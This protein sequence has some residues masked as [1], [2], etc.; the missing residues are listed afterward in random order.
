MIEGFEFAQWVK[1]SLNRRMMAKFVQAVGVLLVALAVCWLTWWAVYY[2]S[3]FALLTVE[4]SA[5]VLQLVT[6]V[7]FVLLFVIY[8]FANREVVERQEF[9]SPAKVRAAKA[10]AI[11]TDSPLQALTG[12]KSLAT[13][14][15]AI[16]AVATVGPGMLA[17]SWGLLKQAGAARSG[18]PDLVG[19]MLAT[20]AHAGTRVP[21]EEL[22]RL[23]PSDR[24]ETTFRAVR[25]F[26]GVIVRTSDPMG[27]ALS[28]RL[29]SE[30]LKTAPPEV[31]RPQGAKPPPIRV[32]SKGQPGGAPTLPRPQPGPGPG[33]SKQSGAS[34]PSKA[35][36]PAAAP[37][38]RPKPRPNPPE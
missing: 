14:V 38:P 13:F 31:K 10:A 35:S 6:W 32:S 9:E 2:I 28:E 12:P 16:T 8:G 36:P 21:M 34:A 7:A 24:W 37:K 27:L 19:A 17:A 20:L 26:D 23:D 29:R 25:L 18:S 22:F 1:R 5:M 4:P 33:A 15:R 3:R 30:I 11:F